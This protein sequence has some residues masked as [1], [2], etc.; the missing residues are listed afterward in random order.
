MPPKKPSKPG[1]VGAKSFDP[2]IFFDQWTEAA[3][4]KEN[5]FQRAIVNAFRLPANDSYEYRAEMASVTLAQVQ[6]AIRYG[7]QG[8]LHR[9]YLNEADEEVR[10]VIP[11]L[12]SKYSFSSS[13]LYFVADPYTM[14]SLPKIPNR[15]QNH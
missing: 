2:D 4:P 11:Y 7:D 15:C 12:H 13:I 3:L 8:G 1:C 6:A 5:D 9:W 10:I 14:N